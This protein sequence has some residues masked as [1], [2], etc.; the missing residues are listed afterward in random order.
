MLCLYVRVRDIVRTAYGIRVLAT[1]KSRSR[2]IIGETGINGDGIGARRIYSP[3]AARRNKT[4]CGST[5][6]AK[7]R[8]RRQRRGAPWRD[9]RPASLYLWVFRSG[10]KSGLLSRSL[11]RYTPSR[12]TGSRTSPALLT[13]PPLK[14]HIGPI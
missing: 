9:L 7:Q 3:W 11:P 14:S 8:R 13:Y 2:L 4:I 5:T 10:L 6:R 1:R 12:L